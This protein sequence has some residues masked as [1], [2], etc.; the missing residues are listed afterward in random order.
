MAGPSQRQKISLGS[1]D[2]S[3]RFYESFQNIIK[4]ILL[5]LIVGLIAWG[6]TTILKESVNRASEFLFEPFHHQVQVLSEKKETADIVAPYLNKKST[7]VKLETSSSPWIF[8]SVILLGSLVRSILFKSKV[9]HTVEGDGATQSINYFLNSYNQPPEVYVKERFSRA[10]FMAALRRM[11]ITGLTLGCGGSGGLEGPIIPIGE[12]IG[13]GLCRWL[14]IKDANTLRALQ[15][16]G[17]AAAVCTLLNAPFASAIFATEIVYSERIVYRTF[18]YSIFAVVV[19][20]TLN[21]NIM[22]STSLFSIAA[23]GQYYSVHEYVLVCLVAIFCS[24]PCGL[25]LKWFFGYLKKVFAF[26]PAFY[27]SPIAALLTAMIVLGLWFS[28]GIEPGYV[29]GVGEHTINN[30]LMQSGNPLLQVWWIIVVIIVAKTLATGLTLMT[31]GSAG[32]LVPAMIL[33][34]AMG[35]VMYHLLTFLSL[36]V[37]PSPQIFIIAGIASSLVAIIEVPLATIALVVEMFGASY[38]APVMVAVGVCHILS[39]NMRLR[40]QR[41]QQADA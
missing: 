14:C 6:L 34:G 27:R 5:A 39:R 36:V 35:A 22:S 33:G 10:T 15:M 1:K 17:I 20:Y 31:G 23:H 18:L 19:A 41:K 2:Q 30:L 25:G 38:A 13:A 12:N 29:V 40:V 3:Y 37:D 28:L 24:G 26:I 16:A 9:W 11:L 32:L 21:H 4:T 7:K 8:L